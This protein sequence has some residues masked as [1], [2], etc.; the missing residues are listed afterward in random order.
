METTTFIKAC[1]ALDGAILDLLSGG[2]EEASRRRAHEIAVA[3]RQSARSMGRRD[4]ESDLRAV[5]SLLSLS[6]REV[7]PIRCEVEHRL[8]EFLGLLKNPT[9]TRSA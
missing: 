4:S 1:A 7:L 9:V 8:F 3:L 6:S 2:W 5:E